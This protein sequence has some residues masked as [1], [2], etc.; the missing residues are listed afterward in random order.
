MNASDKKQQCSIGRLPDVRGSVCFR[1]KFIL[2]NAFPI[3]PALLLLAAPACAKTFQLTYTGGSLERIGDRGIH[4]AKRLVYVITSKKPFPKN[5]C[6]D[7]PLAEVTAFTD[8]IDSIATLTAAGYTLDQTSTL[9]LCSDASGRHILT[10]QINYTF[11][12]PSQYP[13][14]NN[15]YTSETYNP[16]SSYYDECTFTIAEQYNDKSKG[17]ANPRAPGTWKYKVLK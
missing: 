6:F 2:R 8:G 11:S 7:V 15:A 3:L 10:W 1:T 13:G 14:K 4:G 5:S 16:T 12:E 17:M 9:S